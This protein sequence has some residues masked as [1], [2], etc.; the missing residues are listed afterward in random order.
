[1]K[2]HNTHRKSILIFILISF[3]L[4]LLYYLIF[5]KPE[6]IIESF[7]LD[8]AFLPLLV[9]FTTFVLDELLK[10]REKPLLYRKKNTTIGLF[11]SEMGLSLLILLSQFN[12]NTIQLS[13]NLLFSE[14]WTS[15]D[16]LKAK[17]RIKATPFQLVDNDF[18]PLSSFLNEKR[19]F[20][21]TILQNPI[22]AEDHSFNFL[23]L[24]IFHLQQELFQRSAIGTLTP[25]DIDHLTTDI[26]RIYGSLIIEWL[27]YLENISKNHPHLY[28]LEVR[29]NPFQNL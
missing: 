22:L 19:E 15:A 14:E 6:V 13:A 1:M 11:Y 16:F 8:L 26:E 5:G 17:D 9:L 7:F 12:K 18:S 25:A 4:Y 10:I 23:M 21:L 29:I 2:V 3:I 20:M 27:N 28:S 24:S